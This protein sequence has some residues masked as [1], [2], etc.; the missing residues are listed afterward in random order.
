MRKVSSGLFL[1]EMRS[2]LSVPKEVLDGKEEN[3][4]N[5]TSEREKGKFGEIQGVP[6]ELL[7]RKSKYLGF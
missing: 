1:T 4:I 6:R 3:L 7:P 2:D 5:S